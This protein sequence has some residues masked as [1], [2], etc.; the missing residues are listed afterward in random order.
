[1]LTGAHFTKFP[2]GGLSAWN[3]P[4]IRIYISYWAV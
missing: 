2:H 3:A 1:M 4:W